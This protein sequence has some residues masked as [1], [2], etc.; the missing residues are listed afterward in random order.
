[1]VFF[2]NGKTLFFSADGGGGFPYIFLFVLFF[3]PQK[4]NGEMK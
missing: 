4:T 3:S 1:M 2:V